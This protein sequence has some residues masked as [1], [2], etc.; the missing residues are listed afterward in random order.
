MNASK[1]TDHIDLSQF[2]CARARESAVREIQTTSELG[3]ERKSPGYSITSRASRLNRR[4]ALVGRN[5][6]LSQS[7]FGLRHRCPQDRKNDGCRPT[8]Q[9]YA[10]HRRHWPEQLPTP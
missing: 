10:V 7:F 8:K 1:Q 4:Y 6:F 3:H 5:T 2:T 9:Q